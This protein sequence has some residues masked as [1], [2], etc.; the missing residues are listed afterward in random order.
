MLSLRSRSLKLHWPLLAS[1]FALAALSLWNLS[2]SISAHHADIVRGQCIWLFLGGAVFW[3]V[4]SLDAQIV[5]RWSPV[6]YG[7]VLALLTL[8]LIIGK[9][10]NG[11]RRWLDL[12]LFTLQPSELAKVAVILMLAA[13]LCRRQSTNPLGYRELSSIGILLAIPSF[14]IF[15]EPD[16]GQTL[17]LLLT[18]GTMLCIEP[19][20]RQALWLV[21]GL[22]FLLAPLIWRFVLHDYQIGRILTLLDGS[23]DRLGSGW[24]ARQAEIAVGHGGWLGQGHGLGSQISGGFLP[25]HHTDFVFAKLS[26][27]H[28]FLGGS[29]LLLLYLSLLLSI[30][31]CAKGARDRFSLQVSLGVAAMFF[32]HIVLNVGMV[33]GLLPVTGV[34][35]PL[36]SYGGSSVVTMMLSLGLVMGCHLHQRRV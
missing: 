28:G 4:A 1:L 35:L 16:L 12:G 27:E 21:G 30:L 33:L 5:R 22:G 31:H 18:S 17:L 24:H 36:M 9:R 19:I 13:Y 8:V 23:A 7:G 25:E 32:W 10:V 26:E 14:L 2:G 34:T 20:K 6:A 29:L 3:V 11:S 15:R